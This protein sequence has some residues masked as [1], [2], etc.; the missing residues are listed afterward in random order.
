MGRKSRASVFG[1]LNADPIQLFSGCVWSLD[2]HRRQHNTETSEACI[3][4]VWDRDLLASLAD[5]P[6]H[7]PK[8]H[9]CLEFA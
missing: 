5:D 7:L 6:S 4:R 1:E 3:S 8:G 9:R 2:G